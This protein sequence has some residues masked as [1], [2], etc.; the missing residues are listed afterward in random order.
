MRVGLGRDEITRFKNFEFAFE[1]RA[2][3]VP[4]DAFADTLRGQALRPTLHDAP[5]HGC[6]SVF[7]GDDRDVFEKEEIANRRR[8]RIETAVKVFSFK[9]IA[10][11]GKEP[12]QRCL[13]R[14]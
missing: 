14:N 8:D 4:S 2:D 1:D 6:R 13:E 5:L 3:L 11:Y 10:R 7:G 9:Y 12:R